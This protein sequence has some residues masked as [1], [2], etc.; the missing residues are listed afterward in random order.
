MRGQRRVG[1]AAQA[2]QRSMLRD[3][4]VSLFAPYRMMPARSS[5]CLA[6]FIPIVVLLIDFNSGSKMRSVLPMAIPKAVAY[7]RGDSAIGT[8]VAVN[9]ATAPIE[10]A[11]SSPAARSL[12]KPATEPPA[13]SASMT[14]A[15]DRCVA[16]TCGR[17]IGGSVREAT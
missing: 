13:A 6:N 5:R 11:T 9:S 2:F 15:G 12:Q 14:S 7:S 8:R 1:R 10:P 3:S 4:A 17:T 16:R